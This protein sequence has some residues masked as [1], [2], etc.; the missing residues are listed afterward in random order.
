MTGMW[1]GSMVLVPH[2][3]YEA[4]VNVDVRF[5]QGDSLS[6]WA[7]VLGAPVRAARWAAGTMG[8]RW[9]GGRRLRSRCRCPRR[10][11]A[12]RRRRCG[13]PRRRVRI[14]VPEPLV[15]HQPPPAQVTSLDPGT[16]EVQLRTA[17]QPSSEA[18]QRAGFLAYLLD[19][20]R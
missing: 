7:A 2:L 14:A 3:V 16:A 10:C 9:G 15:L 5:M 4:E 8:G 18:V 19:P 17:M 6:Q 1:T 13:P 12:A 11:R 20:P